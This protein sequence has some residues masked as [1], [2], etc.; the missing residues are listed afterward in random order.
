MLSAAQDMYNAQEYRQEL[1]RFVSAADSDANASSNERIK[2]LVYELVRVLQLSTASGL[3]AQS[4][5]DG[6]SGLDPALL[7]VM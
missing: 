5:S 4:G 6:Q 3:H 1:T 2:Q 7:N